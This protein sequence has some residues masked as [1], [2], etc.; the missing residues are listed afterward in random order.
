MLGSFLVLVGAVLLYARAEIVD[1]ESFADHSVEALDDDD[2]REVV[3]REIVVN[4]VERGST[5]LVA[6]RPVVQ[7]VVETIVDTGAFE[8]LFRRAAVEANRLFFVRE[9]ENL[10][11]DLADASE[12]VRFGLQSVNPQLAKQVPK[13][14]DVQV[15]TLKDREYARTTL[16]TADDIRFFGILIPLLALLALA[17]G[18]FLAPDRRVGVLRAAVGV[19]TAGAVL[20]IGMLVVREFIIG[21]VYGSDELSDEDVR[22]AVGGVLGAFFGKLFG[23]GAVL[24]FSGLVVSAAATSLDPEQLENPTARLR[25]RLTRRPSTNAGRVGRAALAI[26]AGFLVAF[27]PELALQ[28][29]ALLVGAYLVFYGAAELLAMLQSP[30]RGKVPA[31]DRRRR[32]LAVAVAAG[33]VVVVGIAV[34]LL[35][36]LDSAEDPEAKPLPRSG[37]NGSVDLCDLRLNEAIFAGTHNSFS[38]ADS[39]GWLIANQKRTIQRQLDDGIRLFL[40]DTHW[41]VKGSDGRVRTDFESEGTDRNKVVKALPP[42]TLA[43]AERVAGRV[44]LRENE[45]GERDIWLCHTTCELGATDFS[46]TLEVYKGFLERNTGEVVILFVEPYVPPPQLE[47]AFKDAGLDEYVETLQLGEPMPTLGQ[48]VRGDRRLLVFSEKDAGNPPWYMD[49]FAFIQDTPLGITDF[50]QLTCDLNRGSPVSPLLMLN[51]WADVFPPQRTPNFEFQ[52]RANLQKRI[53]QC[54]R[55][56]GQPVNLI[57]VDHSDVGDL[58]PVVDEINADRAAARKAAQAA[59]AASAEEAP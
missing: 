4:L 17:A 50:D 8:K 46:D 28:V 37:C 39:P 55:E 27:E 45:G 5:D 49:G 31:K 11:F 44:G 38:A 3:S 26:A 16:A 20:M 23:W 21:G 10:V 13:D 22:G 9:K 30:D 41:G 40:I 58:I 47:Q 12:I 2:V 18:I 33:S 54:Q 42:Q 57:A 56:R 34:S 25:E 29:A 59:V 1:P 24:A 51:H 36:F 43:A 14:L 6:G 15:A 19:A 52:T 7:S 35:V 48:L 32:S 53:A